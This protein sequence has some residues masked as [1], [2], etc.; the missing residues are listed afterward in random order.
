LLR[1]GIL[2]R[3][4]TGLGHNRHSPSTAHCPLSPAADITPQMLIAASCQERTPAVQHEVSFNA[5][6]VV[7][8]RIAANKALFD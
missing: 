6:P 5:A 3:L 4:L 7:E 1:C 2:T 8:V